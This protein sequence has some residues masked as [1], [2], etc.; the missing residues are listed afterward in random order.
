LRGRK[1]KSYAQ[2]SDQQDPNPVPKDNGI[3]HI[4]IVRR[5]RAELVQKLKK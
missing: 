4:E 3:D 5:V 2:S 1:L